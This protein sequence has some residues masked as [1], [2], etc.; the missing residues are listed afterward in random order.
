MYA[1]RSYYALQTALQMAPGRRFPLTYL[2]EA[3]DDIAYCLADLEDGV[4]KG[5]LSC[6]EL[7]QHLIEQ[8]SALRQPYD[9]AGAAH[10]EFNRRRQSFEQIVTDALRRSDKEPINK[11]HEFFVW[12]RVNLIHPLVNHAAQAF[13]EQ[14]DAVYD[15][16]LNRALLED[17]SPCHAVVETLK[18]VAIRQVFSVPEVETLELQGFRIISGLLEHS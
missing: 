8:F 15:G 9:D 13:I 10:F 5:I 4:D 12:L 11:E 3:A 6:A 14:I 16:R 18:R 1:I 7:A 17:D 2:M